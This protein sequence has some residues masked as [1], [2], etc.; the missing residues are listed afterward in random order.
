MEIITGAAGSCISTGNTVGNITS[1]I[2]TALI[3][4]GEL[5]STLA[6]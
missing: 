1:A 5:E 2:Q 4:S 3:I 6:G